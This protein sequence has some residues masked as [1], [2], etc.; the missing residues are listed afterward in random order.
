[1]EV[2]CDME[3]NNCGGEGGW[4]RVAYVN[5]TESGATCPQG[6]AENTLSGLTL[7][8]ANMITGCVSTLFPAL[9]LNYSQVCGQLRG[10]QYGQSEAFE[11]HV[12]SI[13]N[14][15]PN[16]IDDR[17]LDGVSITYGR[18]PRKHIWTFT[19]GTSATTSSEISR[20]SCPCVTGSTVQS[21]PFVGNDYYCEF[22]SES[23]AQILHPNDPL[24]DGQMCVGSEVSCCSNPNLPWFSKTLNATTNEN[25]ELRLCRTTTVEETP[26]QVIELLVR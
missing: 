9:G 7:C 4:T 5:M 16:T 15:L 11:I 19:S 26:L 17:Y 24:W 25:I 6:L 2:Y 12:L 8:G 13:R 21:P 1:M 14:G 23:S 10:Y 18:N 20:S 22:A 3:G